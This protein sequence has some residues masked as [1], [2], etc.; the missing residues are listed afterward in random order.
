MMET[1]LAPRSPIVVVLGHID[2]GKTTLLD[3]LRKTRVAAKESGGI[4]QHAAAYELIHHDKRITF[5]DTPGHEAFEAMRKRG[6]ALADVAVLIVAAD[7]GVKPQTLESLAAIGEAGI[8]FVVA[9]NKID[10]AN[11]DVARVKS[12]LA[13]NGVA[14]EEWGG[15]IPLVEISAK[16]DTNLPALFEMV[17]L[18]AELEEL[19]MDPTAPARGAVLE[20][21]RDPRRGITAELVLRDGIL[22]KGDIVAAG[23]AIA[24]TKIMEAPTAVVGESL[25]EVKASSPVRI[26]GFDALPEAGA[27]F[28]AFATKEEAEEWR[29]AQ[30][31]EGKGEA[32]RKKQG[33]PLFFKTD[34]AGSLEALEAAL[35]KI[36]IDY[37]HLVI[38]GK[39]IGD[40]G[41]NDARFIETLSDPIVFGYRVDVRAYPRFDVIYEA[42]EWLT[43]ELHERI[44]R[45]EQQ[46]NRVFHGS[47]TVLRWF[48]AQGSRQII[49]G[50]VTEGSVRRGDAF[51]FPQGTEHGVIVNIERNKVTVEEIQKGEEAGLS[52]EAPKKVREGQTLHF[53]DP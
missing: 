3:A 39:G 44:R 40:M 34:T 51:S 52:V 7:D 11:A 22:K 50:L 10:L 41:E 38:A 17:L 1:H 53:Y 28:A 6:A 43:Q 8:P 49:G 9:V 46:H 26:A 42:L 13:E 4:T 14:I 12:Q 31:K 27:P 18:I 45:E 15:K 29:R 25:D 16:M 33:I 32:E 36:K 37:P 23:N 5:I 20:S 19:R 47:L 2:H 35:E 30:A 24:S 48:R 21:Y